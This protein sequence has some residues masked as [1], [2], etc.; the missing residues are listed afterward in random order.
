MNNNNWRSFFVHRGVLRQSRGCA[1]NKLPLCTSEIFSPF[2][3]QES[4]ES[5]PVVNPEKV[6]T[7]LKPVFL[8]WNFPYNP[9]VCSSSHRKQCLMLHQFIS[10]YVQM[11]YFVIVTLTAWR[12]WCHKHLWRVL[13]MV[14]MSHVTLQ[15]QWKIQLH[16]SLAVYC[17]VTW[18]R[19]QHIKSHPSTP[20]EV[21]L[22]SRPLVP[23]QKLGELS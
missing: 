18:P 10:Y 16:L 23:S 7:T 3:L 12:H 4:K 22:H 15:H 9:I 19:P 5:H 8:C 17:S 13:V 2:L 11:S 14:Q 21:A 1:K 20:I 6:K